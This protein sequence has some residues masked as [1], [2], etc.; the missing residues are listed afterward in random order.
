MIPSCPRRFC[1]CEEFLIIDAISLF[2]FHLL[3]FS[4]CSWVSFGSFA[5]LEICSF[6][7]DYRICWY[8]LFTMFS[9]NQ[10]FCVRPIIISL[11]LFLILFLISI[12]IT[13]LVWIKWYLMVSIYISLMANE[14][15]STISS[16]YWTFY[17]FSFRE[18]YS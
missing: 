4:I 8:T 3:R 9:Y 7:L 13:I 17:L 6:H 12:I 5:F 2:V 1:V 15:L 10:S 16:A 11:L 18:M 14:L